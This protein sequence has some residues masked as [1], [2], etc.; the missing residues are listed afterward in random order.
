[1]DEKGLLQLKQ[2]I[3]EA[4]NSVNQL[5]GQQTALLKQLKDEWGC[6]SIEEAEKRIKKMQ[7]EI[8]TLDASIETGLEEL[9]ESQNNKNI[10]LEEV[11]EENKKAYAKHLKNNG[12]DNW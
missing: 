4:K 2:D 8:E 5:K 12:K 11:M 6:S 7:K 10:R 3:D 9:E 1:M